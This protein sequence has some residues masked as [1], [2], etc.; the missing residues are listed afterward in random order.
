MKRQRKHSTQGQ[1]PI[2]ILCPLNGQSKC[3]QLLNPQ[4]TLTISY[5]KLFPLLHTNL[6]LPD[7]TPQVN[8]PLHQNLLFLYMSISLL[9][10]I[11]S[12]HCHH[13]HFPKYSSQG[14]L[15]RAVGQGEGE[16]ESWAFRRGSGNWFNFHFYNPSIV[17]FFFFASKQNPFRLCNCISK[18]YVKQWVT[19]R[20]SAEHCQ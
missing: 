8:S 3:P 17:F 20:Y 13:H 7:N 1:F 15:L 16:G 14:I 18:E 10:Q 12:Q 9:S 5:I 11:P 2:Q 4:W 6:I 19:I